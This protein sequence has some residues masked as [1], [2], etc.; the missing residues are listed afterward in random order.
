MLEPLGVQTNRKFLAN[1]STWTGSDCIDLGVDELWDGLGVE[2]MG[3]AEG[4]GGLPH[5]AHWVHPCG[6]G[7]PS[8]VCTFQHNPT[9]SSGLASMNWQTEFSNRL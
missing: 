5:I 8:A 2:G 6:A 3:C 9:G 1:T 4:W 7:R